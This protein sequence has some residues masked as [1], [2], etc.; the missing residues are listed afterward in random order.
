MG[1]M[2]EVVQK[3]SLRK[4]VLSYF[5]QTCT[6]E[7]LIIL[8]ESLM[9][10]DP[11]NTGILTHELFHKGLNEGNFPMLPRELSVIVNELD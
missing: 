3:L 10:Q 6:S 5:C 9:R 4:A 7:S 11:Q 2:K 1:D 8:K